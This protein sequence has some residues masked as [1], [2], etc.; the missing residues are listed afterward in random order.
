MRARTLLALVVGCAV[1][2]ASAETIVVNG[3]LM[4]APSSVPRPQWGQ[5]M[6]Q[7]EARFGHPEKRYPAVGEHPPITRW[8]YPGYSVYFEYNRVIDAVVH[9]SR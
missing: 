9:G 1:T 5:T 4:I 2:A 3:R 7:V 8:N 6:R